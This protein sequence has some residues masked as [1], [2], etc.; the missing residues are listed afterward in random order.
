MISL[1]AL[2]PAFGLRNISPFCLKS[3]MAL[4]FLKQPFELI[5]E[6]DPRKAP[7]GK[8]PYMVCDGK[9]VPDSERILDFLDKRFD[10]GLYGSLT[11]RRNQYWSS[12]YRACRRTSLLDGGGKSLA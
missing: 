10:G 5:E 6:A 9:T 2:P 12:I 4:T 1:Y 7:K 3:A 11:P 8:L